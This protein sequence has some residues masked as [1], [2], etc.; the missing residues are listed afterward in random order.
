MIEISLCQIPLSCDIANNLDLHLK[1]INSSQSNVLV[2]PECSLNGY[3]LNKFSTNNQDGFSQL[4]SAIHLLHETCINKGVVAII[5]AA[6]PTNNTGFFN[7][8]LV[9]GGEGPFF[10]IYNKRYLTSKEKN[11]FTPGIEPLIIKYKDKKIGIL[12]CRDQSNDDFF[13]YY[14]ENGTDCVIIQS[15]HY[16]TAPECQ[17]KQLKN[18]AIPIVRA[19]DNKLVVAKVNTVRNLEGLHSTGNSIVAMPNGTVLGMLG[20]TQQDCLIFTI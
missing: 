17:Q 4:E 6:T 18:I 10:P 8:S 9:L 20:E 11:I 19:I 7:S 3:C 13:K 12:I 15:A 2:F 14:S 5:G 16:Y 1:L